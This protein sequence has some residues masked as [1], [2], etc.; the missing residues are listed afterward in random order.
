[1]KKRSYFGYVRFFYF[2]DDGKLE[3]LHIFQKTFQRNIA[4]TY[5]SIFVNSQQ[6][7]LLYIY[8]E[9]I[10]DMMCQINH[11]HLEK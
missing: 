9:D 4:K 8:M 7:C 2:N 5:V 1:M 10:A 3:L 11:I 6:F